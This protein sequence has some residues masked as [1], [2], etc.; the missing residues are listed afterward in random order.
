MKSKHYILKILSTL[1]VFFIFFLTGCGGRGSVERIEMNN[2]D[3]IEVK[4]GDFSYDGIKVLVIYSSGQVNEINLTENMIPDEDKLYFYKMGEHDV[5]VQYGK[6]STTMKI[7]VV[8]HEFD[9]IYRLEGYTCVYDGLPHKVEI[10]YELPEGATVDYPYGN[11]FTNAGNYEV[12]AVISKDGYQSKILKTN[13]VIEEATLDLSNVVFEDKV[14]EYDGEPKSIEATNIPQGVTVQYEIWN[15]D[16]TIKL[17]NAVNAG[18]YTIV[19]KY[20]AKDENYNQTST[21][22]AKLTIT[23]SKYD[24]SNVK[25]SNFTK[26]YD[27]QEYTASF[28]KNSSLPSGVEAEFKYYNL[29]GEEVSSTINAGEYKIIATFKGNNPNYEEIA[30]LE[31]KLVVT[32]KIVVLDGVITF[33]SKTIN[34]DRTNHSLEISGK[35]PNNVTVSYENNDQ[36]V[37]G[38]YKVLA[39][40]SDSN[41]NEQLDINEL[42][43]YLIINKIKETPQVIDESTGEKR[44][45][46]PGDLKLSV[47]QETGNKK[48]NISGFIEDEYRIKKIQYLDF[49]TKQ[50]IK[51]V[52]DF[53]DGKRYDYNIV[54]EF[55]NPIEKDSINLSPASGTISFDITFEDDIKLIDAEYV[56][57]GKLHGL[58]VNK[59]LPVGTNVNYPEG[60]EFTDV[61]IYTIVWEL[62]KDTYRTKQIIGTLKITK[63]TYDMS[64]VVIENV[65]KEY[66]G[67]NYFDNTNPE[68]IVDVYAP[69]ANLPDGVTIKSVVTMNKV[70]EDWMDS[71]YTANVGEYKFNVEFNYDELNYNPLSGVEFYLTIEKKFVDLSNYK[72]KDMTV[73]YTRAELQD[74]INNGEKI[75]NKIEPDTLPSGITI[76]Y[77][78]KRKSDGVSLGDS[79]VDE[80]GS[81]DVIV[82]IYADSNLEIE[83]NTLTATLVVDEVF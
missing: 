53:C 25:L 78:Y 57:D 2:K 33:N 35:L 30:P 32:K 7:N 66:D 64:K 9:D 40:F 10:N 36:I 1:S 67:N 14:Y 80:F 47:D 8:S 38:E 19:S 15:D 4:S 3:V 45:I 56:Y 68:S 46:E 48:I 55:I 6:Y 21:K 49:N 63:A 73:S 26:E 59:E 24:M 23:K 76:T 51:N 31:A 62:S 22:K 5:K 54:F 77:E 42:E 58:A 72:L 81:F 11:T 27:G 28:D 74:M 34:F 82:T 17:N 69:F 37:A 52:S 65:T 43:A 12:V 20:I 79:G 29:K 41:P 71:S 50:E 44:T 39:K 61:G 18:T 13:L 70:G 16:E 60:E 83:T 75:V